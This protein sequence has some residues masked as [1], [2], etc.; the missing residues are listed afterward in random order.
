MTED[1]G[2][3]GSC[4]GDDG[5]DA[6]VFHWKPHMNPEKLASSARGDD[7]GEIPKEPRHRVQRHNIFRQ[8]VAAPVKVHSYEGEI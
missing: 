4:A 7:E 5:S 6:L 8:E 1:S 3:P 2:K